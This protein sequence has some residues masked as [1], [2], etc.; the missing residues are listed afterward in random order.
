MYTVLMSDDRPK[1]LRRGMLLEVLEDRE[2]GMLV[3]DGTQGGQ[4]SLPKCVLSEPEP[5]AAALRRAQ[6]AVR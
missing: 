6:R 5:F 1:M 2:G 3:S 4:Y